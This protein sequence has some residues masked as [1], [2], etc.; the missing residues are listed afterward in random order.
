MLFLEEIGM[1]F[2]FEGHERES[3][4]RAVSFTHNLHVCDRAKCLREMSTQ[5][6]LVLHTSRI[7][8]ER[9]KLRR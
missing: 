7:A 3:T 5:F 9:E 8:P 1:M 4:M 2:I 6:R